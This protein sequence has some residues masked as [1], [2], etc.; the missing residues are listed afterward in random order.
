MTHQLTA[1]MPGN[2]LIVD[3]IPENL[4]LLTELLS[5]RGYSVRSVRSGQMALKTLKVKLPD[6]ILLDIKMPEMD[7]YQVC[8]AVK[9][10][11]QTQHI[12][13]I[14]VSALDE[15]IDKVKAFQ[16]GGADYI[17]K[18]FH[19]EEVAARLENQLTLQRQQQL[20]GQEV[21]KRKATEA[22]LDQSKTLLSSI[23]NSSPDGIAALQAIRHQTTQAITDFRCLVANPVLT[24][25]LSRDQIQLEGLLMG[26]YLE[27]LV[28]HLPEAL[29]Q[30]VDHGNPWETEFCFFGADEMLWYQLIAV[31]L[32][33]GVA[34]TLRNMTL[35]KQA[36]LAL[37]A[38]NLKLETLAHLDSL[39]G[40]ANRRRFDEY[41]IGEWLRLTRTKQPLSLILLDV[42]YFKLY[43][44]YYGHQQGDDCLMRLAQ[45]LKLLVHRS[46]DLVAR[47]GGEEFAIVLPGT[48]AKGAI[49]V[50]QRVQVAIQALAMPHCQ[51][52][53]Q[54]TVTVSM[55]I[56]S[57]I[58]DR[59]TPPKVLIQQ[60]DKTLYQAKQRGRNQYAYEQ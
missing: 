51:S 23:L 30:V 28:S 17:T 19:I 2:I 31:K 22:V 50:A 39:T 43:N 21:A 29:I 48:G 36:E 9:A 16:V 14:F 1:A 26:E 18:P 8:E 52:Q 32:G 12:P 40:V 46:S 33:D 59:A 10:N 3:D 4:R 55:G 37:K 53:V 60:A 42:D 44:D 56:A 27:N 54:D 13:I 6:L 5:Q 20:L 47:Y 45:A 41:F 7:G 24:Q 15:A 49:A 58:P 38:A 57:I 35:R 11:A 34:L 25:L